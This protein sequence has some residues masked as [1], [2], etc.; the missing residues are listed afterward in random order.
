[1]LPGLELNDATPQP[2]H[3]AGA[4]SL[5]HHRIEQREITIAANAQLTFTLEL[6]A[7]R[8]VRFTLRGRTDQLH[9]A[10]RFARGGEK[11]DE[12]RD[13]FSLELTGSLHDD[14]LSLHEADADVSVLQLGCH[15]AKF[16]GR[17]VIAC[18]ILHGPRGLFGLGF[19]RGTGV[20][21]WLLLSREGELRVGSQLG[22]RDEEPAMTVEVR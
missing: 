12:H 16:Q 8:R 1:M 22:P 9:A 19:E 7:D 11:R 2:G 14:E 4:L 15:I 18:E 10:S 17:P 13:S 20:D 6:A 5:H 3:Y 21:G